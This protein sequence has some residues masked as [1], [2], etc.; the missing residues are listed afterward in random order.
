MD[1]VW[2]SRK[3]NAQTQTKE[4]KSIHTTMLIISSPSPKFPI[5]KQANVIIYA[6][7]PSQLISK[8]RSKTDVYCEMWGSGVTLRT[9]QFMY[10]LLW[11]S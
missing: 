4:T 8:M 3:K 11:Q 9:Q 1:M 6:A 10:Q 7:L 2:A 5:L